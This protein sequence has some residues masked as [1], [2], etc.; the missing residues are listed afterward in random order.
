M[1]GYEIV[2]VLS[3]GYY[4]WV[5]EGRP[6]YSHTGELAKMV[7]QQHKLAGIMLKK[8]VKLSKKR[9][10]GKVIQ[11]LRVAQHHLGEGTSRM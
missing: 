11:D 4:K 3:G 1:K 5:N 9:E 7:L 8:E 6:I 10:K 2:K